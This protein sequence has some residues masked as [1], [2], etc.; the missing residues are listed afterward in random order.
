MDEVF[1]ATADSFMEEMFRAN[2]DQGRTV[3]NDLHK[4][5]QPVGA[6]D[7]SPGAPVDVKKA[8]ERF[9]IL[10][11]NFKAAGDQVTREDVAMLDDVG[12]T[13]RRLKA[14]KDLCVLHASLGHEEVIGTACVD[15]VPME[16][17]SADPLLFNVCG[18]MNPMSPDPL[19]IIVVNNVNKYAKDIVDL[20]YRALSRDCA[21]GLFDLKSEEQVV[22]VYIWRTTST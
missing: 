16:H 15:A 3:L 11:D 21:H 20:A 2:A 18:A 8:V 12:E 4:C 5:V 17:R 9:Q 14:V 19:P 10:W 13:V 1:R 6:E 22:A 7:G